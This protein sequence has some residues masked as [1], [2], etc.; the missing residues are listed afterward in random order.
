MQELNYGCNT[1]MEILKRISK[2]GLA[3]ISVLLFA[4]TVEAGVVSFDGVNSGFSL[5][6]TVRDI[7]GRSLVPS[8]PAIVPAAGVR[9]YDFKTLYRSLGYP[10]SGCFGASE[11]AVQDLETYTSQEDAFYQEINNYLRFYPQPYDWYGTGP[12]AAAVIVKNIDSVFNQVPVLPYDLILFRGLDLKFRE[13]NPY[14]I[15]E[16]FVDKGYVSTSVS[17]KVARYF[18]IDIN[19]NAATSS[20]KAVF[21]IYANRPGEKGILIDRNEDEVI[22]RHGMRFKVM[23]KKSNV[24]KYD[25]YLVQMCAASCD[26]S[27]RT[28]VRDFWAK[29]NIED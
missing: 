21:T 1:D 15:N 12:E 17:Y 3:A 20:R 16:E 19:D 13:G 25:L 24:K 11:E 23:A 5:S 18:A 27:L 26:A 29:F 14:A 2:S 22:L 9:I 8:Q 4:N 28:D 7:E 6:E 10:D